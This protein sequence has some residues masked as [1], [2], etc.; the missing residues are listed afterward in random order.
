MSSRIRSVRSGALI[1]A[2]KVAAVAAVLLVV[3]VPR[4]AQSAP[5]SGPFSALQ[6]T[7]SGSGAIKKSD[8][9]S[10]RIRCRSAYAP[11]G[12]VSLHL[13]L[14]CASDAFIFDLAATVINDGGP[15]SGNWSETTRNVNGT[16]Q[17][18]S[19]SNG[20]QVQAVIQSLVFNANLTLTTRGD[21]QSILILSPGTE[22]PEVSITLEKR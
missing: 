1:P 8:G 6:G 12:T 15:I 2:L 9:T 19:E 22:V 3:A 5:E 17:G 21:R 18:R 7:W 11:T 4:A 13:G 20:R 14:R 16:I 10:E